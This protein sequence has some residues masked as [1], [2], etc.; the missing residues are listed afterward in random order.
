MADTRESVGGTETTRKKGRCLSGDE[1]RL[2][3]FV[4]LFVKERKENEEKRLFVFLS[5]FV[6]LSFCLKI[7]NCCPCP[8]RSCLR[9]T[10]QKR[11]R[12]PLR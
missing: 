5:S 4:C 7:L 3:L 8:M 10:W 12:V 2:L 11:G 9:K 6:S 1:E